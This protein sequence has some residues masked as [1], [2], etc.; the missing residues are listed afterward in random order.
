MTEAKRHSVAARLSSKRCGRWPHFFAVLYFAR[1][2]RLLALIA[3]FLLAS[4]FQPVQAQIP[5]GTGW[6]ALPASTSL[7]GSGACPPNYFDGDTFPFG[8]LC[9]NVIR[10]WSGAIADTTANRL[11]IWGGGHMNY[12]GNEIYSLNLTANPITLTRVKDPTV[13]TNYANNETCIDG[14]PP[15]SPNFA[16]NSRESYGGM[17]F[18][19]GPYQMFIE[20]GSLACLLGNE[21]QNTWTIS[22]NNLSN[23][24]QWLHINPTLVGPLPGS[25]GGYGYG[26]VAAYDP[27]TGLVFLSDSASIYTYN[28]PTN[29]YTLISKADY[30]VTSIY[31]SGAIDP[32]RKLL[33]LVGGCPGGTCGPGDGVFVADISN[34]TTT[35]RQDWT[36]ATM[37]DPV[38]AQFLGGGANPIGAGSPGFVYD[39]VAN[40]FVG[41]PNQGNSVYILTPDTVNQRLT[42]QQLTFPNGPPNSSYPDG[43]PNVSTGTFGRFRYFPALDVF[44]L[45]NDWNIPAYILRLRGT[46]GYSLAATPT[47]ATT[48]PGGSAT[49][50]VSVAALGSFTG[51]VNLSVSGSPSGAIA[52]FSPTSVA[53]GASS[54]LTITTTGSTPAGS[55]TLTIA[56]VSGSQSESTTVVLSVTDFALSASPGTVSTSAGNSATYTVSTAALNGF[57]GTVSLA[58]SGLPTNAT[59]SFNPPSVT[60]GGN[61]TLTVTTSA[62]TPAGN[63]TLTITG[64]SASLTHTASV[65]LSVGDFSVTATSSTATTLPGGSAAYAINVGFLNGFTGTVSLSAN[66][67]PTGASPSFNPTSV[68]APGSSI[69]T[70]K[71]STS[72]NAGSYPFTVTGTSGSVTESVKLTLVVS[73][74]Q[75]ASVQYVQGNYSDPQTSQS[76]VSVPFT[77]AQLAGDLNVVVVGW[78]DS[79]TQVSSV[80]DS[81]GNPYILAVGPTVVSGFVSQAIYYA[82]NIT[83]APANGNTVTVK[84]NGQAAY[85]DIRILEYS[86]ADPN[87]PLDRVA[88]GTGTNSPTNSGSVTTTNAS[89]LIFGASV[90][91]TSN[92]GPGN[93]FTMR[94]LTQPNHNIAEDEMVTATGSYS[95]TAPLNT[96]GPWIMQMVA[97]KAQ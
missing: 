45:V 91:W 63:S 72:L 23:A 28:F 75:T 41:W 12:Y 52:S 18:I 37:A 76:P 29:T 87:S 90:V 46:A 79:T 6:T 77:A 48:N 51:S 67:L 61:S 80:M 10:A 65:L 89:D 8:E 59:F 26:N 68:S 92:T 84:F 40:D 81:M 13:P 16:P 94:I 71:A 57:T 42:C 7:Q 60:V 14:I 70:V 49:Y 5:T 35:S 83:A 86:G 9:A 30:F 73:G 22:L 74:V 96:T 64:T 62:S 11:I 4:F 1:P 44:V 97:F 17:E 36:A 88:A 25:D 85:P 50:T 38:C 15:G 33:V 2:A 56:G 58:A 82:K 20:G 66:G 93:G 39:S 43:T 54:T 47:T 95:A 55:S 34:P 53:V 32:V 27:N 24:S 69:L 31:L 19:P 3:V 78:F 21:S